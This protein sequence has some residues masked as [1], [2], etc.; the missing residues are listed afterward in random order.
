MKD[1][2]FSGTPF[3]WAIHG[4]HSSWTRQSGDYAAVVE[5]LIEAGARVRSDPRASAEVMAVLRRHGKMD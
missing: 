3:G 2:D 4:S 5:L 1:A